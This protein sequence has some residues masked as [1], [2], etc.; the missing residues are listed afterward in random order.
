MPPAARN[1]T[2]GPSALVSRNATMGSHFTS[3]T[4][5][6]Q[7]NTNVVNR[8]EK[9]TP[10]RGGSELLDE[11]ERDRKKPKI[12]LRAI[13]G[14]INEPQQTDGEGGEKTRKRGRKKKKNLF[15]VSA[16]SVQRQERHRSVSTLSAG[17]AAES[18]TQSTVA[19]ILETEDEQPDSVCELLGC[20]YSLCLMIEPLF[21]SSDKGKGKEKSVASPRTSA[22]GSPAQRQL[23]ASGCPSRNAIEHEASSSSSNINDNPKSNTQSSEMG[24]LKAQLAEQR[25]ARIRFFSCSVSLKKLT[26][27]IY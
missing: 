27:Y 21:K 16:D 11:G 1:V 25:K 2:P 6:L 9:L 23:A 8:R 18:T 10:K 14:G 19:S 7:S 15:T 5:G 13:V 26:I 3:A 17:P 24:L 22:R 20:F 12:D 4:S